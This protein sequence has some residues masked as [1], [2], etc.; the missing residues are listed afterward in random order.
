MATRR[1]F[2]IRALLFAVAVMAMAQD[3]TSIEAQEFL[4]LG[5]VTAGGD[6][7]GTGGGDQGDREFT[8][9]NV[10]TGVLMTEGDIA[11]WWTETSDTDGMNPAPVDESEFIDSVFVITDVTM[12]IN[13]AGAAFDFEDGDALGVSYNHVL[14]NFTQQLEDGVRTINAGGR[15]WTSSV[16]IHG[17]AGITFDLEALR[18]RFGA[19]SVSKLATFA[20]NVDCD[21]AFTNVY[22]IYS[23]ADGI[24]E[25]PAASDPDGVFRIREVGADTG[26]FYFGEIPAAATFLTLATGTVD[27]D[28]CCDG[29]VFANPRIFPANVQQGECVELLADP[30]ELFLP[31]GTTQQ[32]EI[33]CLD[34]NLIQS[35]VTSRVTY[36][37]NPEGSI[38]VNASGLVTAVRPGF[39]ELVV[40]LDGTLEIVIEVTVADAGVCQNLSVTPGRVLVRPAGSLQLSVACTDGFGQ[41]LD[42]TAGAEGTTYAVD[43]PGVVAVSSD[44]LITALAASGK[45]VVT[46]TQGGFSR[47]LRVNVFEFLDLGDIVAFGDGTGTGGGDAGERE[48]TAID[49]DTGEPLAEDDAIAALIDSFDTDGVNPSP[50]DGSEFVDRVFFISDATTE[51]NSGGGTFTWVPDDVSFDSFGP[52]LSNFTHNLADGDRGIEVAFRR[53][54]SSAVGIHASAGITFDLGAL[55]E[56]FGEAAIRKL[57]LFAGRTCPQVGSG[58]VNVYVIFSDAAGVVED[59]NAGGGLPYFTRFFALSDGESYQTTIPPEAAYLTFAVG[60]DGDPD[61]DYGVFANAVIIPDVE[62]SCDTLAITPS[63]TALQPGASLQLAVECINELG[64]PADVTAAAQGTEYEVDSPVVNVDPDGLV[65]ALASGQA[66]VTATN[67]TAA[68]TASIR[69][70]EFI[71]LGDLVAGG[72]GRGTGGGDNGERDFTGVNIDTG[73]LMTEDQIL[74]TFEPTSDTNGI[75]PAPVE[76]EFVD[77][78]F[79]M[80]DLGTVINLADTL[81]EWEDGDPQPEA[82]SHVFSNFTHRLEAGERTINAGGRTDWVSCVGI[83]SAAGITFDLEALRDEYGEQAVHTFSTSAGMGPGDCG[84]NVARFYIIYS[85]EDGVVPDPEAPAGQIYWSELVPIGG[86]TEYRGDIPPQASFLT[87]ATGSGGDSIFCDFGTFAEARILPAGGTQFVRADANGDGGINITDPIFVLGYLFLG[88]GTPTCIKAADTD[89]T[90]VVNVTDALYL[91]NSLFLGGPPPPAPFPECGGDP[92]ADALTCDEFARCGP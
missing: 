88:I 47:S 79:Y 53:D 18:D 81:F 60:S 82:W 35:D 90:G 10:D 70:A 32:L 14:S 5:D 45:A 11:S 58:A 66:L 59:P 25:D 12:P 40:V 91:L 44:G 71:D 19:A 8:A 23:N 29:S 36:T 68:G 87:L 83:H 46:V 37:T 89:D 48:F 61:C 63:D 65:T 15:E 30:T 2:S 80:N 76:S 13:S 43:P 31:T 55:R 62:V 7:T 39:T 64:L 6:G 77:S 22:I 85:N 26:G 52:I 1:A 38:T 24:V 33:T 57:G 9:I 3:R 16:G 73:E 20:G 56:E 84:E 28:F 17:A 72:D 49:I 50:V 21:C 51:I 27:D 42:K 69:V 54:W 92:T 86:I 74:M 41:T 75:N 78:V 34:G 67:G 4:D